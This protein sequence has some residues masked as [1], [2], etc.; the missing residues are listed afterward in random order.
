MKPG[1]YYGQTYSPVAN[2]KSI[3]TLIFKTTLHWWYT[4]EIEFVLAYPQSP[5]ER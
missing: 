4:N 1:L 3:H 5:V 2:Q